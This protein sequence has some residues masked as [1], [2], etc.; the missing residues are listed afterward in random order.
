[1]QYICT[2]NTTPQ[3]GWQRLVDT[4]RG[5]QF[6]TVHDFDE[7]GTTLVFSDARVM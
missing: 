7:F 1:M 5:L 6:E 3:I 2:M 4:L